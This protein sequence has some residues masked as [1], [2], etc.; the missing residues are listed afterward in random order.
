MGNKG[1]EAALSAVE[2]ANLKKAIGPQPSAFSKGANSKPP[3][4]KRKR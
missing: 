3:R 4:N 1:L 2:M